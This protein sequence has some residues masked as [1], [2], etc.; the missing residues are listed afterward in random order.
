MCRTFK[1]PTSSR[2]HAL[3]LLRVALPLALSQLSEMSMGVT[4]TILLG[5]LGVA[6]VAVGGL[7]NTFFFTTMVTCQTILGGAGVLLSHS[8]GAEDH[9][10]DSHEGRS[11]MSA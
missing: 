3:A 6:E 5:G 9:G 1:D 8:R 10:R 2:G 11:V 4:D 7:A